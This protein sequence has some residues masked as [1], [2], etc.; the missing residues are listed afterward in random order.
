MTENELK[1]RFPN[2]TQAF[3]RANLPLEA[4]SPSKG[5]E[6]KL[7][8]GS[9]P[10]DSCKEEKGCPGFY[11]IVVTCYQAILYDFDNVYIKPWVDALRYEG[12]I[13]NDNAAICDGWVRR[14][15]VAT[16]A[17]QKTVIEI[18]FEVL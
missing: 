8:R 9:K 4:G 5:I 14:V 16:R 7:N 13:L 17:E 3:I 6:P 2:A 1:R 11:F 15:K 12:V 10:M 18:Y